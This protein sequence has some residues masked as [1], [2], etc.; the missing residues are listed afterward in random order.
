MKQYA[1]YKNSGIE[2]IGKIPREW[3]IKKMKIVVTKIGSGKTPKGGNEV[4]VDNGVMFLRSQNIHND[5]LSLDDVAYITD[6]MDND[7]SNTRLLE[8]DV[9]LNITGASIGRS[10]VWNSHIRGNVNQ[11]VCIIRVGNKI[12]SKFLHYILISSIGQA[13]IDVCQ[14]GAN[15]EGLNF[16]EIANISIP[17][18]R[19]QEQQSI[20]DYLDCKTAGIDALIADKQ[21]LI[22]LLREKRQANISEAVTRGLDKA[23]KMKDSGITWIGEIPE[24][25][26]VSRMGFETWVRARLGWKGL[27][28]E[29]YVDEGYAFLSTPNIKDRE[30]DFEN[31]NYISTER[32]DE[33]PEIK[34]NVGDILLA[35]DGST[36]GTINVVRYLPKETTVNS[37][38][39]V[40]TPN[41]RI[42]SIYLYYLFQSEYIKNIIQM[43]KGGMGVP[44]LFQGDIVKFY[45]PVP[46]KNRQNSIADYLDRKTAQLDSLISDIAEQIEKLKEYRQSIISEAVSGKVA[47]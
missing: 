37:S 15:R 14:T 47:V 43:K 16:K 27:K 6:D 1:E 9:L 26:E 33:S 3:E 29:E 21:K 34:L 45:I 22:D 32:F 11:H 20:I 38:I 19:I 41:E 35:K 18:T 4:Y 8:N 42:N 44:H 12:A 17:F 30:I 13:S 2:W 39:A 40:I 24:D 10:C 7:L 28:A 5:G 46:P 36:L 25:W 31:V 23:I